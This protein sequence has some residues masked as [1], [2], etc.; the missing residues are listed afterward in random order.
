MPRPSIINTWLYASKLID[1]SIGADFIFDT[2]IVNASGSEINVYARLKIEP[3][4]FN[5]ITKI[6]MIPNVETLSIKLLPEMTFSAEV[7]L[8]S[9]LTGIDLKLFGYYKTGPID[10]AYF[11]DNGGIA[12][13]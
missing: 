4:S 5:G 13:N 1:G 6:V 10:F 8:T 12:A 3:G 9:E 7:K 11:D 2:T